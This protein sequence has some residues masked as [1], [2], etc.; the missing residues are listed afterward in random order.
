[1]IHQYKDQAAMGSNEPLYK[2][3]STHVVAV[4]IDV[5]EQRMIILYQLN[6]RM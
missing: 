2:R 4:D 5:M 1:M 6:K 3:V